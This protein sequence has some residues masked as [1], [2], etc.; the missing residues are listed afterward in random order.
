MCFY[1]FKC[2]IC[3]ITATGRFYCAT[4]V[5]FGVKDLRGGYVE[6]MCTSSLHQNSDALSA[7]LLNAEY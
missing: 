6:T 5:I 7:S 3:R 1:V 2:V 4:D